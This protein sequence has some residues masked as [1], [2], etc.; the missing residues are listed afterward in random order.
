MLFNSYVF[1]LA[2]LPLSLFGFHVTARAGRSVAACWLIAASFGFYGWWNPAFV[3]LLAAS[4]AFN[5]SLAV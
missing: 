2:F 1:M 5:L 4:I 3:L